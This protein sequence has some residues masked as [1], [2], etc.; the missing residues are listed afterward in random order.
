MKVKAMLLDNHEEVMAYRAKVEDCGSVEEAATLGFFPVKEKMIE[1]DFFFDIEDVKRSW[2]QT[3]GVLLD[4]KDGESFI[5]K[6][7]EE[8]RNKL[9]ERFGK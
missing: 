4:F 6:D 3:E 7:T 5:V 8:L 1:T 2:I 9:E